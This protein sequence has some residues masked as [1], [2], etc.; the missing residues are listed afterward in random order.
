MDVRPPLAVGP[1]PTRRAVLTGSGAGAAALL[2]AACGG[3]PPSGTQGGTDGGDT[4]GGENGDGGQVVEPGQVLASADDVPVGGALAVTVGG[5]QLLVTQPEEGTFAAFS[6][7]CTHE[8]CTV[9]PGEGELLCPCHASRYDLATGEVL[10][11]PAPSPLPE[12]S[13]TV[14]GGDVTSA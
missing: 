14:E 11:G 8:R 2:L 1:R 12:V 5:A 6:A 7:I 4:T 13:V 9:G 3:D 10:G